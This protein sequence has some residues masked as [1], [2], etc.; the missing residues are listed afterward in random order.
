MSDVLEI[1]QNGR[2]LEFR[3]RTWWNRI[4]TCVIFLTWWD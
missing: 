1:A 2:E 4:Y 3:S